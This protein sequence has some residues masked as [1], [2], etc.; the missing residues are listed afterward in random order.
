MT[1]GGSRRALAYGSR[2]GWDA[3]ALGRGDGVGRRRAGRHRRPLQP[4]RRLRPGG[5]KAQRGLG[6]S[7]G[8]LRPGRPRRAAALRCG[9][10]AAASRRACA[11]SP[12]AATAAPTSPASKVDGVDASVR[13][14]HDPVAARRSGSGSPTPKCAISRAG[15][16]A[17]RRGRSQR[18]ARALPARAGHRPG[19]ALR[20]APGDRRRE[21]RCAPA[22]DWRRTTGRTEEDFFFSGVTPG[23][24]RIAGGSSDT[25]GAFA[26]WTSGDAEGRPA[27]DAQRARSTAGGWAPAIGSNAISAGPVDHR[28]ALRRA[29][30]LGGQRARGA[31]LDVGRRFRCA[32]RPI[33][34]GACR[35]STN[36][37]A[38]SAS[39]PR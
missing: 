5:R 15:S 34:A 4:R 19:R 36:S 1:D 12:T 26:E 13:F 18:R 8:A 31:A 16:R 11:A 2:D 38:R 24:H 35:R 6:G 30:G 32:P 25:V 33:A 14:V 10:R 20:A 9:R 39:A 37:I 7:R 21:S 23:R 3:S 27:L 17:S 28:P 22:I 29:A